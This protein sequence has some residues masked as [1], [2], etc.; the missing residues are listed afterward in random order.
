MS[1]SRKIDRN[2]D[3]YNTWDRDLPSKSVAEILNYFINKQFVS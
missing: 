1:F 3:D 2:T